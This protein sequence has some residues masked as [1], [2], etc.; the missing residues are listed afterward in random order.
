MINDKARASQV[1]EIADFVK[2]K[3]ENSPYPVIIAGI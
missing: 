3:T 1:Q 2:S